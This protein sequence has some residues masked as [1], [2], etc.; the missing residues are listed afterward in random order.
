MRTYAYS[1]NMECAH[2]VGTGKLELLKNE[3]ERYHFDILGLAEMRWTASEEMHGC[4]VIWSGNEQKHEA[5]VGFL[6]S[7]RAREALLGNK[8]VSDRV[9]VARFQAQPFNMSVVQVYAPTSD[10]T[11]EQVEQFYADLETTLDDIPKKDIVII[12]GDWNA[13]VGRDNDRWKRVMGNFGYGDKK[14]REERLLE[15]AL[16]P[17]MMICNTKFQQ[18]DCRK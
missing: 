10:G 3:M 2:H 12:A 4:K 8:P 15:F 17:D 16:E 9:M 11:N 14:D 13:K 18:K 6:L 5:G 7:K 1:W